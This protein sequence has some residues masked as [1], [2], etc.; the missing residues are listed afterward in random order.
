[1][2]SPHSTPA[3][4]SAP[5]TLHPFAC[6][7][8]RERLAE[9]LASRKKKAKEEEEGKLAKKRAKKANKKKKAK[10]AKKQKKA[11]QPLGINWSQDAEAEAAAAESTPLPATSG[12]PLAPPTPAPRS[13]ATTPSP[14]PRRS[15]ITPP[16]TSSSAALTP[17][18]TKKKIAGLMDVVVENPYARPTLLESPPPT[19]SSN[20]PGTSQHSSRPSRL[21]STPASGKRDRS[22]SASDTALGKDDLKHSLK[23]PFKR[24]K[25]VEPSP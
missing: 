9:E 12:T 16:S 22:K 23:N 19:L 25:F 18:S 3:P 10:E 6:I 2:S 15:P 21:T 17:G 8:I 5:Q 24:P 1:M 20:P 4:P 11:L 13:L 14:T 7:N